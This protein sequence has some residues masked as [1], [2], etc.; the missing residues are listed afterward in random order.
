M[1]EQVTF[2]I[3]VVCEADADRRAATLLSDRV[4]RETIEWISPR[5]MPMSASMRSSM[6][7]RTRT[8][9]RSVLRSR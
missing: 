5:V 9:D 2:S 1:P 8:V 4:L 6:P 3:A 7:C